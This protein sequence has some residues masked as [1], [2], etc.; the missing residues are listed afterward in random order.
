MHA[1]FSYTQLILLLKNNR[2]IPVFFQNGKEFIVT[3]VGEN[4]IPPLFNDTEYIGI[5]DTWSRIATEREI[6]HIIL[7]TLD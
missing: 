7:S 1:W 5:V 3:Q 6:A 4:N 2:K